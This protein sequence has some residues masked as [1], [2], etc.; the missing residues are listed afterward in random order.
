MQR[1]IVIMVAMLVMASMAQASGP[2]NV[3]LA[4]YPN[5][6]FCTHYMG[7]LGINPPVFTEP[8]LFEVMQLNDQLEVTGVWSNTTSLTTVVWDV[9]VTEYYTMLLQG[10]VTGDGWA[11]ETGLV[12]VDCPR[13]TPTSAWTPTPEPTPTPFRTFLPIVI[14]E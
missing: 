6:T 12:P 5:Q 10:K 8:K 11:L 7:T 14:G 4:P 3:T 9:D 2:D 13:P 1:I